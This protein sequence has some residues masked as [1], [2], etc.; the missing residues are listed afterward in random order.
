M[1][2][3]PCLP[4]TA[5]SQRQAQDG[6]WTEPCREVRALG[7]LKCR[8]Q[9]HSHSAGPTHPLYSSKSTTQQRKF[10]FSLDFHV[11]ASRKIAILGC[12]TELLSFN[13]GR[14]P[15]PRLW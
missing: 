11:S 3:R 8:W 5:P 10:Q 6:K 12:V 4:S 15:Q 14:R 1:T 2:S 13:D 9:R 7:F